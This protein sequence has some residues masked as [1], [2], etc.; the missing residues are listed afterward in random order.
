MAFIEEKRFL[1]TPKTS[2]KNFIL[3]KKYPRESKKIPLS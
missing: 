3:I 2:E 1:R